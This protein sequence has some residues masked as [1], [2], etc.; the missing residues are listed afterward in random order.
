MNVK[1]ERKR[2]RERNENGVTKEA[3]KGFKERVEDG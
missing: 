1:R 2:T 3:T